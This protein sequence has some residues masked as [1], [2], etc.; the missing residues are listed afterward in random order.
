MAWRGP[1]TGRARVGNLLRERLGE[2]AAERSP[3]CERG[4]KEAAVRQRARKR[5]AL[6]SLAR[7]A[8]DLLLDQVAADV[9]ELAVLHAGGTR[10]LAG[11]AGEATVEVQ[12][13]A[14]RDRC[15]LEH[16][17]HEIDA[18]A[19]AVELVAQQGIGRA[20]VEAEAAV[21]ALAQDRVGLDPF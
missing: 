13:R 9:D 11:T 17:L 12:L 7:R 19:R 14:L 1:G 5:P 6:E 4:T 18:A 21:H 20:G 8:R 16:L 3:Q 15:A 2:Q 10:R